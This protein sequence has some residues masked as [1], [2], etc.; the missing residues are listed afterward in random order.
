VI[1]LP[2]LAMMIFVDETFQKGCIADALLSP[3]KFAPHLRSRGFG[4]LHT[5]GIRSTL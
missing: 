5:C 2:L 1:L 4:C 3:R